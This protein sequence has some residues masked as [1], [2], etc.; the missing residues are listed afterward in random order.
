MSDD[1]ATT[2][3]RRKPDTRTAMRLLIA[4]VKG[5]IPFGL[6]ADELCGDVCQGC[7]Q[8]LL[9]FLETELDAWEVRLADGS[10][11]TLGDIDRL[12]R[13]SRKIYR[14]LQQNGLVGEQVIS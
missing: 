12:A 1:S 14:V 13:Q 2:V 10:M 6:A 8:K 5:A 4:Q 9:I 3:R 7:S 11:P